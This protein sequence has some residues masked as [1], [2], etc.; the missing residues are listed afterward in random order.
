MKSKTNAEKKGEL[1]IKNMMHMC[2]VLAWK[3]VGIS[4]INHSLSGVW[5]VE[6]GIVFVKIM[7]I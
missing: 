5:A 7:K 1:W 4:R 6:L 2:D 3:S